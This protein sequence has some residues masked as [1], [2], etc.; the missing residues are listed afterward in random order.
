MGLLVLAS[1]ILA[2]IMELLGV[3]VIVPLIN[4]LVNPNGLYNNAILGGFLSSYNIEIGTTEYGRNKLVVIVFSGVI[5]IYLLKNIFFVFN[6]WLKNKYAFKVQ[7]EISVT[8]MRKYINNGYSFFLNHNYSELRQ[9]IDGDVRALYYIISGILQIFTQ[10]LIVGL[11]GIY[12]LLEDIELAIGAILTGLF[13]VFFVLGIF[14]RKMTENGKKSRELAIKAEKT[15]EETLHGIKL[16]LLSHKEHFFIEKF[17]RE[18]VMRN[19]IDSAITTGSEIPMYII[20]AIS[21]SGIMVSLC[22]R[23]LSMGNPELYVAVLGSFA[24]GVFRILPAIG[25]ISSSVN[26]IISSAPGLNSIYQNIIIEKNDSLIESSERLCDIEMDFS[27]K[28][29]VKSVSFKYSGSNR[30]ILNNVSFTIKRGESIGIIGESGAGKSTLADILLGLLAPSSGEVLVDNI[31]ISYLYKGR[32]KGIGYVPQTIFLTDS[33]IAENVAYGVLNG[34]IDRNKVESA[35][36]RANVFDFIKSLPLGIDTVVGDRGVRLSG[37]QR[38]RIG[39]A[40][41][42]YTT[43]DIIILDEATSALDNETEKA[44]MDAIE[45][46]QGTITMVIIAHRLSTIRKCDRVL[47]IKNGHIK[48]RKV[49]DL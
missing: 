31:N 30:I 28:I 32:W 9:G 25:K 46:L 27:N 18:I 13:C 34:D 3:S 11:I 1:S 5:T 43:P 26:G 19:R 35:L 41:A 21:I 48:E 24:V 40:R 36:D 20:E 6:T 38:Q 8:M 44:V 4:A 33:T 39:I 12:M 22:V 17:N 2:A 14:R 37:G 7:R 29:E 15:M 45:K 49:E 47:E 42:L 23:I 10:T 16:V